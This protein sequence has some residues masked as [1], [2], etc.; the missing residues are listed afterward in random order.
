[1]HRIAYRIS[2]YSVTHGWIN[3]DDQAIC[4]Y[5][6]ER[7]L[8]TSFFLLT[9]LLIY[10]PTGKIAE[11]SIF[12]AV[13]LTFRRRTGGIHANS[14]WLCQ[15]ISTAVV[16]L[17]VFVLG[18]LLGRLPPL[19]IIISDGVLILLSFL[20]K[21]SFPPQVHFTQQ[22]IDGNIQRKRL[23]LV[24]LI[25]IQVISIRLINM[26]FVIYSSIGLLFVIITVILGKLI[27]RKGNSKL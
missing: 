20:L 5:A 12:I 14:A 19:I 4:C 3:A 24:A 11:A 2:S 15:V 13:V 8:L 22:D 21:P 18:P 6:F 9:Q 1:M 27:Y 26:L 16:L 23:M 10:A 17:S 25:L 7:R